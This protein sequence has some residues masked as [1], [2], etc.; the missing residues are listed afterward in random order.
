MLEFMAYKI[1]KKRKKKYKANTKYRQS[2]VENSIYI[3]LDKQLTDSV[4]LHV[5]EVSPLLLDYA[6]EVIDKPPLSDEFDIQQIE[7]Y[8][9]SA[10]RKEVEIYED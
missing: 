5:F 6:I 7:K 2:E 8:L 10:K 4:I 1:K 9:F 3:L